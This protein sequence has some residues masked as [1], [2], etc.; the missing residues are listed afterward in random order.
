VV[1]NNDPPKGGGHFAA[2]LGGE[3]TKGLGW[4]ERLVLRRILTGVSHLRRG[5]NLG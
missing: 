4:K 1:R 2:E 3:M 5:R